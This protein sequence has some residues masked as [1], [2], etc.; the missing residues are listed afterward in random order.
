MKEAGRIFFLIV[1]LGLL[2]PTNNTFAANAF[3][4]E[5]TDYTPLS[6]ESLAPLVR[7]IALYPDMLVQVILPAATFPDQIVD[8]SLLIKSKED[9]A[10]IK[11]Q[12]WDDSVKVVATY[13][14]VLKMMFEELEWTTGLGQAFLNQPKDV[15]DTIQQERLSAKKSGDLKS[16]EQQKVTSTTVEDGSTVVVIQPTNPEVIY[17][18]TTTVYSGS[19]SYNYSY[20]PLA[21]F[22]VGLALGLALNHDHD[23]YYYGGWGGGYNYWHG[24]DHIDKWQD[25]RREVWEDHNDRM[26]D[27]QEH[28]QEMASNRQE[29]RQDNYKNGNY[30]NKEQRSQQRSEF[31]QKHPNAASNASQKRAS[32]QQGQ[33]PNSAEM[34]QKRSSAAN[35]GWSA[36]QSARS[37]S[38]RSAG[39]FSDYGS[40]AQTS[41]YSS[42]GASSRSSSRAS[43]SRSSGSAHSVSRSGGG[44]RGGRGG[45]G[46]R[47]R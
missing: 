36:N 33:R 17:V 22:G 12:S 42:R 20:A 43:M 40:R 18:P 47:R 35:S 32:L 19:T 9:A 44:S 23:N 37:S 15:L 27:K 41:S 8:A 30:P 46:G 21:T 28:R 2:C 10:T 5:E 16:T 24:N 14:G 13:P 6:R 26:W 45:G 38:A 3:D 31:N 39:G 25:N 1:V 7:P 11:N 34:Q 4:N 29:F